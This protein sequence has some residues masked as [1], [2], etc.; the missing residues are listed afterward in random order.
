MYKQASLTAEKQVFLD[1]N[2]LSADGTTSLN[3]YGFSKS[4]AYFAYGLSKSGSDWVEIH[5]KKT[6]EDTPLEDTPIQ[7]YGS[8]GIHSLGPNLR[9]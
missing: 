9:E 3:T 8:R 6:D 4:G 2:Q 7:W 1:P 5:V